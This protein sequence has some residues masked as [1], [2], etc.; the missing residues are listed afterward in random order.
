MTENQGYAGVIASYGLLIVVLRVKVKKLGGPQ[1]KERMESAS[2][3]PRMRAA[4]K[5][6]TTAT[7]PPPA[8]THS[9]LM[10]RNKPPHGLPSLNRDP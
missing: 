7:P 5:Q 4:R 9:A 1:V 6:T 10:P 3:S 2:A 8:R